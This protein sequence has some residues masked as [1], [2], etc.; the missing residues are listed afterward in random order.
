MFR[1]L[2]CTFVIAVC[3]AA[4]AQ[5]PFSGAASAQGG[6]EGQPVRTQGY[7]ELFE[8]V[9]NIIAENFIGSAPGVDW[10]AAREVYEPLVSGAQT[11]QE[12]YRYLAEMVALLGDPAT[13]VRAPH[14]VQ[15]AKEV[16]DPE[17]YS[18]VGLYLSQYPDGSIVVTGVI[19]RGPA[20]R[21]GVRKGSRVFAVD[22]EPVAGKSLDEVV[23]GIRGPQGTSVSIT[24]AD[25]A[26]AERTIALRRAMIYVNTEVTSN[27]LSGGIGYLAIPSFG[28]GMAAQVLSHLRRL[29]R[30]DALIIDL[31]QHDGAFSP[32]DFL[33]I[34]G[35]FTAD[36]L[37]GLYTRHGI[38]PLLPDRAWEGGT[39]SLGVPPPTR[40]D[41][42]EKPIAIIV[43]S[44]VALSPF[45]VAFVS[46]LAESGKAVVVGRGVGPGP[47]VGTGQVLVEL[48]GGGVL[49]VATS[50]LVSLTRQGLVDAVE[51]ETEVPLDLKYLEAWYRGDDLDIQAARAA[52]ESRLSR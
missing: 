14:E 7:S 12:A 18:G 20:A 21:A 16:Q 40:L 45:T 42:W 46:S 27:R 5:A 38:Y 8:A 51:V 23:A 26:G 37:G 17:R 24:F 29:Y 44:S 43:D 49:A 32:T 41:F 52:L 28:E 3:V 22:G 19:D 33:R 36:P 48:P 2:L 47:L 25:P 6:A 35:L 50:R 11:E 9:W 1:R 4:A 15:R 13:F 10:F 31:R 39:G 34:A 30:S